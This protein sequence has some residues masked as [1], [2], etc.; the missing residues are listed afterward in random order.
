MPLDLHPDPYYKTYS[1]TEEDDACHRG[2]G[3]AGI[4]GAETSDCDSPFSLLNATFTWID[5]NLKD[6]IDFIVWTGDSARHDN[7]EQIPRSVRQVEA[8]NEM[9][10]SK[11]L[12]VFGKEDDIKDTHPTNDLII[13]IVPTFGNN[14]ILP[15]NI[16]TPG[17][18]RWTRRYLTLWKKFIPEEQR[19]GFSRGGWFYVEVIPNTLAVFSLNTLYFHSSN[20]AVD[21]CA[22]NSEP[23]YEQ[24]EWLR[25]QLQFLRQRGMKAIISG[26]V[27]P[28]RTESKKSWDETCWHKYTLWMLQYRDVVVGSIYGHMN[29]DH[30]LLQDSKDIKKKVLNGKVQDMTRVAFEDEMTA[31]SLANY[32][33]ELR[34][35]WAQLPS[36]KDFDMQVQYR[37]NTRSR[38]RSHEKELFDRIGGQWGERY[39]ATLVGPS[40]VPNYFPSLRVVSY[41]ITGLEKLQTREEFASD[42]TV[43]DNSYSPVSEKLVADRVLSQENR[44][45][46]KHRK[47]KKPKFITPDPPSKSSPPGPAY[48][49]QTLTWL[50]YTQYYANLTNINNDF[51]SRFASDDDSPNTQ[52]WHKGKHSGKEPHEKDAKPHPKEFS[53]DVEYDTKIDKIFALKDLTVRSYIDLAARIGQYN[54]EGVDYQIQRKIANPTEQD[55]ADRS[56]LSQKKEKK[57]KKHKKHKRITETW[58]TFVRRAFVSARDD[59]DLYD[60]F[61]P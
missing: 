14:D 8:L 12:E 46:N 16:F 20:T 29:I 39:S 58:F 53:F 42:S 19:H 15:H 25:I 60:E 41:N 54:S 35:K 34:I 1:S 48:S 4:L 44:S 7:D 55:I 6:S 21:G 26:H 40:L 3:P 61:S 38:R 52:G 2:R 56:I 18:N 59:N 11:F 30:F 43:L 9:V 57:K 49:P 37:A 23:G 5:E 51:I 24:M 36:S 27:P 50:S 33:T 13:P 45:S 47:V 10:V 22:K 32:L 31:N 28:A 17:P